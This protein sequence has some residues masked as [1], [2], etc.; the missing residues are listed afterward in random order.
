MFRSHQVHYFATSC[1]EKF[2]HYFH[3]IDVTT[4]FLWDRFLEAEICKICFILVSC[5]V[6]MV[7]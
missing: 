3:L 7:A 6:K 4:D 1:I 2:P 5:F